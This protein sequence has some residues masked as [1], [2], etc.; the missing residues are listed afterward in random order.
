VH[1]TMGGIDTDIDGATRVNGLFAAGEC[2][3]VSINGANRLGSNSLSELLVFGARAGRKAAAF[4]AGTSANADDKLLNETVELSENRVQE[5]FKRSNEKQE[6]IVELRREMTAAMEHGAGIYRSEESLRDTCRT[7]AEIRQR[8]SSIAL[9]DK[10][11][12]F[13]TDLTEALELGSMIDVASAVAVSAYHRTESRGSHQ[14]LD[15]VDRNDEEF[16][17]H[18]LAMYSGDDEPKIDYRDVVITRSKPGERIYGG[19]AT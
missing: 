8:Y 5:L 11:N 4:A 18:T 9:R 15:H 17:R 7:M 13:N 12:V 1:Y 6:D 2:A 16:L 3:C 10:S 14:R 19:D